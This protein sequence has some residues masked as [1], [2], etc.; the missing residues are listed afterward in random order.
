MLSANDASL[1]NAVAKPSCRARRDVVEDLEHRRALVAVALLA[2]EHVDRRQ[3]AGRLGRGERVDAVRE[4]AQLRARPGHARAR[5]RDVGRVGLVALGDDRALAR[6]EQRPRERAVQPRAPSPPSTQAWRAA[7]SARSSPAP[8]RRPGRP[9]PSRRS[10]PAPRAAPRRARRPGAGRV[11]HPGARRSSR[12]SSAGPTRPRM[13]TSVIAA[14]A[15]RHAGVEPRQRG[16][17]PGALRL[18]DHEPAVELALGPLLRAALEVLERVDLVRRARV[19]RRPAPRPRRPRREE[20]ADRQ[21]G[22]EAGGTAT[23]R[24]GDSP[25]INDVRATL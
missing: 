22:R 13:S 16:E 6:R 5:P 15:D 20:S 1:V 10:G 4:R 2:G 19:R 3:L 12:A 11:P 25:S 24:H 14:R 17:L 18:R 8:P 21:R 9:T 23:S 7:R